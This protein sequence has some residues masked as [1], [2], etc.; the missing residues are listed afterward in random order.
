MSY[1]DDVLGPSRQDIAEA[2]NV[3]REAGWT[4]F[5]WWDADRTHERTVARSPWRKVES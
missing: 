5:P 1:G 4:V 2:L 3:L